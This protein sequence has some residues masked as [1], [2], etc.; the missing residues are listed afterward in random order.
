MRIISYASS[1]FTNRQ[2]KSSQ[3]EMNSAIN[4]LEEL[5][6]TSKGQNFQFV[7]ISKPAADIFYSDWANSPR[8]QALITKYHGVIELVVEGNNAQLHFKPISKQ[9]GYKRIFKSTDP[10]TVY[11][12]KPKDINTVSAAITDH[13][14]QKST[15]PLTFRVY[16]DS[17]IQLYGSLF[18]KLSSLLSKHKYKLA[19][20]KTP[21]G[22]TCL[23]LEKIS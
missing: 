21:E 20:D 12:A 23:T 15:E 22:Y 9:T 19:Q 14:K 13:I 11:H 18:L 17:L 7:S 6:E 4:R 2:I 8:V 5:L 10:V 3:E 1:V 16:S